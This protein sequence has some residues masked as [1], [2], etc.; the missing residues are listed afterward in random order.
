MFAEPGSD[1]T[2]DTS[3]YTTTSGTFSS[4]STQFYTGTRSI[5][6]TVGGSGAV[7]LI[8]TGNNVLADAGRRI[9]VYMRF[10]TLPSVGPGVFL[11]IDQ[12]AGAADILVLAITST[13]QLQLQELNAA[14][15]VHTINGPTI[16][17]AGVWYQIGISYTITDATHY[18]ANVTINGKS[19]IS[20]VNNA[21]GVTMNISSSQLLLAAF[22][23]DNNKSVWFDNVFVDN[24]ATLD[25]PG[26]IRVTA[27]RPTTNGTSAGFTTQIGGGGS[28]YGSGHTPQVNE[29]PLSQTNGW[30]M[31]GAGASVIEEYNVESSTTGDV[32]LTRQTLVD[33]VAWLLASSLANETG[34]LIYGVSSTPINLTS[35][36]LL[37]TTAVSVFPAVYPAGTGTDIGIQTTTALTTVSLYECGILVIYT[38]PPHDNKITPL[39]H[40][41]PRVFR[42]GLAR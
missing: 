42:P 7:A 31:V 36:P 23:F 4:D 32:D 19:E 25:Y 38:P 6:C 24:G 2:Y 17:S 3:F 30:S 1:A 35:T 37:F 12:A 16:L 11:A 40:L 20:R 14:S 10:E 26:D 22:Q 29:R 33:L 8:G 28:G 39:N 15:I 21:G 27:K 5:K 41:R 9:S 34:S 13:G 18:T